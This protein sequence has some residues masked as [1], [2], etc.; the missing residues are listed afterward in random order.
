M[1]AWDIR[2]DETNL[3]FIAFRTY[4]ALGSNRSIKRAA[5]QAG[6][7]H[8]RAAEWSFKFKWVL[9][10]RAYEQA[11]MDAFI[12]NS[13]GN[14]KQNSNLIIEDMLRDYN[15]ML[16]IYHMKERNLMDRLSEDADSV[17][18]DEIT[19]LATLRKLIDDLGR[20]ASNLPSVI[21]AED[22]PSNPREH[23]R[24]TVSWV[25]PPQLQQGED[26]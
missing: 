8:I 6:C 26:M 11:L 16:N 15:E 4:L 25:N 14:L 7:T 17:S 3:N 22:A 21:R 19:K 20:R 23:K 1:A 10:V 12:E 2:E 24:K 5:A 9:R 13:I 18:F